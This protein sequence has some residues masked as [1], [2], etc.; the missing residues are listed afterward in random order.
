DVEGRLTR[1]RTPAAGGEGECAKGEGRERGWFRDDDV[2]VLEGQ[3]AAEDV[4]LEREVWGEVGD[5]QPGRK[6]RAQVVAV[7]DGVGA[8]GGAVDGGGVLGDAG[9]EGAFVEVGCDE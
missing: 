5:G 9:A 6:D 7:G 8:G 3:A 2:A 1:N 4:P